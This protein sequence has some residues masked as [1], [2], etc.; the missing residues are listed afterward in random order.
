MG[1]L[2]VR[3]LPIFLAGDH[4]LRPSGLLTICLSCSLA[5]LWYMVL[6]KTTIDLIIYSYQSVN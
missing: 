5:A 2:T 4:T 3:L 6:G 1:G